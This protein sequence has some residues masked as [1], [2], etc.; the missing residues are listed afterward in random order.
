MAITRDKQKPLLQEA[1]SSQ[2]VSRAERALLKL[3]QHTEDVL[4]KL[5]QGVAQDIEVNRN[6]KPSLLETRH[7]F[8]LSSLPSFID[9][10]ERVGGGESR[11]TNDVSV[12]NDDSVVTEQLANNGE[13][14]D[15]IIALVT[16]LDRRLTLV[17]DVLAYML[18]DESPTDEAREIE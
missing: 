9:D 5:P 18:D 2:T 14:F 16:T 6:G 4:E 13:I 7:G 10:V 17:E 11:E 3:L 8:V 12:N 15:N 1:S